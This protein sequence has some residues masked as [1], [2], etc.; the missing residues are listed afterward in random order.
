MKAAVL[1][2]FNAPLT[3][4]EVDTPEVGPDEVLVRVKACSLCG[5]DLKIVAGVYPATTLP[6]IPGHE[7]A[8]E[9][10]EVGSGVIDV[11]KGDRVLIYFYL[12]CG[13]CIHCR[14]GRDSLCQNLKGHIGFDTNGGMAEYIVVP[15]TNVVLFDH[16]I[17]FP[18]AA[19]IPDAMGT[20]YHALKDRARLQ[21]GDLLV[22]VGVGGL[23]LHALQI[24]KTFG[25][26][27]L[28]LDTKDRHLDKA[29]QLGADIV[30]NPEHDDVSRVLQQEGPAGGADVVMDLVGTPKA[31]EQAVEYVRPA[32]KLLVVGY[33]LSGPFSVWAAI[34]VMKE[35]QIVGCR[36]TTRKNLAELVELVEQRRILPVVDDILPLAKIK[37]AYDRLDRGQVMGRIVV[38]P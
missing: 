18:Q 32:G 23:G 30:L 8:G 16:S 10:F 17:A 36:A 34:M 1:E 13:Q 33:D 3:I 31:I 15:A 6:H 2:E 19:L 9:V 4:R 5:S 20:P 35:L 38:E 29:R 28:A 26:R 11:K 27:V 25:A 14:S 21:E 7:I 37:E 24:A 12:N 22:I